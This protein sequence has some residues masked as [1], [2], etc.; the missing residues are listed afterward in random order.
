MK[1]IILVAGIFTVGIISANTTTSTKKSD[2]KSQNKKE[3]VSKTKKKK[4][5][6]CLVYQATCTSA[7]TCQDWSNQQFIEWANQ[8]QDNYCQLGSEFAH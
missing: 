1:K 7:Y 5:V 3:I 6:R 2:K 8:I 4:E